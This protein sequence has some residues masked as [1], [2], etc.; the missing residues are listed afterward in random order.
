MGSRIRRRFGCWGTG[1]G[2][3]GARGC[4]RPCFDVGVPTGAP[5]ARPYIWP[6]SLGVDW[7]HD[8]RSLQRP[9]W[10]SRGLS[11]GGTGRGPIQRAG[12]AAP[13]RTPRTLLVRRRARTS[14]G[15][16]PWAWISGMAPGRFSGPPGRAAASAAGERGGVR[17]NGPG[18][19]GPYGRLGKSV[20]FSPATD[21]QYSTAAFI[22]PRLSQALEARSSNFIIQ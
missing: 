11:R 7:R 12:Q 13:L 17:Y 20:P 21:V 19:P 4:G 5:E 2:R 1:K 9:T 15:H 22:Q 18:R 3:D 8:P 6:R 14:S 16:D 10:P